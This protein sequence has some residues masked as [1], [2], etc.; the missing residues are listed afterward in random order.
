MRVAFV[1]PSVGRQEGQGSVNRDLLDRIVVAGHQVDVYAGI[2]PDVRGARVHRIPRLPAWQLGNQLISL[3]WTTLAM[4]GKRYDVVHADAGVTLRR[5]DVMVCHTVTARWL[6]LPRA[7]WR[8]QGLRGLNGAIATRFKAWLEIAQYRMA[9]H[10]FANSE[11]TKADLLARGVRADR[12]SVMP[13]AVD[14]ERFRPASASERAAARAH[15]G[16]DADA[17]VVLAVG[18]HGP[19]KGIAML[20]DAVGDAHLLVAGEHR[21]AGLA[22]Q[23]RA[24]GVAA[25]MPGKLADVRVAYWA[26]DVLAYPTRYDAFGLSVLEAMACGLPVLVSAEAGAAEVVADAGFVLDPTDDA[27]WREELLGLRGDEGRRRALGDRA[28]A[29]AAARDPDIAGAML[30]NRF[31]LVAGSA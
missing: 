19:R 30:L 12:V 25:T 24:R 5:A 7:V 16:I 23:A 10:V 20:L 1:V 29:I 18:A 28:R 31:Q 2:A 13:F 8:E 4:A 27:A 22:E 9:K 17:F 15:L 21:G 26:A 14:T 11:A 6:D 3:I